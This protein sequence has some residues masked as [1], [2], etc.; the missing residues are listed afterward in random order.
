MLDLAIIGAGPAALTAAIYAARF[1][2]KTE[3]FERGSFGGLLNQIAQI[4][5]FPGFLTGTGTDLAKILKRQAINAG[6]KVSYGE[7]SDLA[8]NS[9]GSFT[10]T[11]DG[12]PVQARTVLVATGS[13]PRKLDLDFGDKPI[14]YC[15]TCDGPLYRGKTLLVIGG[16]NSAIGE[17]V[18]LASLADKIILVSRDHITA[19]QALVAKLRALPNVEIRENTAITT[20]LA[21][22]VDGIFVFIG[23]APA[24][25]FLKSSGVLDPDGYVA[26]D[27]KL[28]TFLPGLFAAGDV[29]KGTVKQAVVAAADG[30]TAAI[31]IRDFLGNHTN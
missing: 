7:C 5:N 4:D 6:A 11:L 18:H 2:L 1:G 23:Q 20:E 30:A 19:E 24:T 8:K 3:V 12:Q 29:R 22:G 15:S 26:T 9:D 14:S 17:A 28:M 31:S 16:G 21:D 27:R 25:D 13:A 10:L